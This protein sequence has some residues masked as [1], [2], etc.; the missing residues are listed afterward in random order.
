M[1]LEHLNYAAVAVSAVAYFMVG[2]IWFTPIGF[3]KPWMKGH[4]IVMPDDATAQAQMKKEMPK[5]FAM[6]FVLCFLA[7]LSVACIEGIA[8]VNNCMAGA[9]VGLAAAVFAFV[10]IAQS[11]MY[12]RKSF[13]LVLIDAG[14][15]IVSLVIVG[16]ILAVWH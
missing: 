4:G 11:H 13:K 9:K 1:I 8:R 3:S 14:Y 15:H 2:S 12:T 10:A 7:V 16:I 6:T 5:L